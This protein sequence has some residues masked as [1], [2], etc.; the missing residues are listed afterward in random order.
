MATLHKFYKR[1]KKPDDQS[2]TSAT[3]SQ[4]TDNVTQP[5]VA[6]D[7]PPKDTSDVTIELQLPGP[8]TQPTTSAPLSVSSCETAS[9]APDG[10]ARPAILSFDKP[11]HVDP[12]LVVTQTLTVS[13]RKKI[14]TF[15]EAWYLKYP[16][17]HYDAAVEGVLC[18]YCAKAAALKI[19]SLATKSEPAFISEGFSNW[20]KALSRFDSHEN[21]G[22]HRFSMQQLKQV[23]T[24]VDSLLSEQINQGRKVALACLTN[25]ITSV[26]YLARQGLAFRGHE[27]EEGN[28]KQLLLL[29]TR[30]S[31]AMKAWLDR[32]TSFTSWSSQ[33]EVLDMLGHRIVRQIRSEIGETSYAIIVDGTQDVNGTEQESICL[34]H[35]DNDLQAREDFVGFYA[36]SDQTSETMAKMIKDVLVRLNLP[37]DKLRGQAYDGAANMSGVYSGAQTRIKADQPLALYVHCGAH[38]VNLVLQ[39][40]ISSSNFVNDCLGMV[41]EV[42][43]LYGRS[44]KYRSIFAD[45]AQAA[46]GSTRR[47]KPLCPTRWTVRGPAVSQLLS[48]YNA[49]CL[50]L[51]ELGELLR[52]SAASQARGLSERFEKGT[53]YLGLKIAMFVIEPLECLNVAVQGSTQTV[54]GMSTAVHMVLQDLRSQRNETV[55]HRLFSEAQAKCEELDLCP[56]TLPRQRQANPR[57]AGSSA[58]HCH[59]TAEDYYRQQ[60]Y[61][62][63]DTATSQ[64]IERFDQADLSIYGQLE[65]ALLSGEVND[66]TSAYPELSNQL[67]VQLRLFRGQH[68]YQNLKEAIDVF[69]MLSPE[70]RKM[71]SAVEELIR[72]CVVLP[73]SSC[74]AERS[75]SSLRRLFTWLRSTMSQRRLSNAAVCHCHQERLDSL[76][77]DAVTREF[78][79]KTEIRR[80]TFGN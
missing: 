18:F 43:T 9:R 37:L 55:F 69:R 29:R 25:T 3:G 44:S 27:N 22:C 51:A 19:S 46:P 40:A 66:A 72:L 14:R 2:S 24:P 50:S 67:Q 5:P 62:V 73:A 34:R 71:L 48:Q 15:Q 59:Q 36:V 58:A 38:C 80:N 63:V 7:T 53:T 56:I 75:F 68:H 45:T 28:F 26:Q 17:L 52:G 20:K 4:T 21:S 64:L 1:L 12:K 39:Q 57:Y 30:E 6:V 78:A 8:S 76:D 13:N 41:N 47:L 16:W 65:S 61:K 23:S 60:F 79:S 35:V 54:S 77:I 74:E 70:A 11:Q 42:G 32:T 10:D 33:N 49:V 31:P